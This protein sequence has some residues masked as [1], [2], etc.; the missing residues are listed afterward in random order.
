MSRHA[1]KQSL[2]T[3][4]TY[5]PAPAAVNAGL[6]WEGTPAR[7]AAMPALRQIRLRQIRSGRGASCHAGGSCRGDDGLAVGGNAVEHAPGGR[8]RQHLHQQPLRRVDGGALS[9]CT[10]HLKQTFSMPKR[11]T[12][13]NMRAR[14]APAMRTSTVVINELL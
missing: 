5:W 11:C 8:A 9:Q 14:N 2:R 7:T 4:P 6:S 13:S 12:L 10:L 3:G 1:V